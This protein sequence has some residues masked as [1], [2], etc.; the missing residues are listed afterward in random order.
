MSIAETIYQHAKTLPQ[1]KALEVL[2][3]VEFLESKP[4]SK[5]DTGA[6]ETILSFLQSLLVG[7]RGDA[8]INTESQA[9]RDEWERVRSRASTPNHRPPAPLNPAS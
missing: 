8:E 2:H 1:A 4:D 5:I 9:F 7:Q 6:D 3:F